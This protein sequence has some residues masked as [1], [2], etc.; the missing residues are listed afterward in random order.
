M[1]LLDCNIL[2]IKYLNKNFYWIADKERLAN[3]DLRLSFDFAEHL[4]KLNF[5]QNV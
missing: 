5:G 3:N 1:E 2:N 4:K